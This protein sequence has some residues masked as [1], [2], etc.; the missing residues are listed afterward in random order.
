M[1]GLF[2]IAV[3]GICL[4]SCNQTPVKHRLSPKAL[5]ARQ[6]SLKGDLLKT[7][8]AFSQLAEDKGRG[9]AFVAYADSSA[10]MLREYSMPVTG[11]DAI[12]KMLTQYADSTSGVKVSWIPI[13]SDVA[14]SGDLG[15]TYGTYTIE[16]KNM[17]HLGGTYCTIWKRTRANGWKFVLS[18]GNEGVNA[19]GTDLSGL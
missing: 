11:K 2:F 5:L 10:T 7:D 15:Y 6:D 3:L 12:A 4:S 1:K 8:L 14:L 19:A 9:T 17:D 16:T 13:T 18:T